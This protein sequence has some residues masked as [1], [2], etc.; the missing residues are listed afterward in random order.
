LAQVKIDRDMMHT[1]QRLSEEAYA[2][3]DEQNGWGY[4]RIASLWLNSLIDAET[5]ALNG[6]CF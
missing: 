4:L 5:I 2:A 6:G 3:G 1:Y